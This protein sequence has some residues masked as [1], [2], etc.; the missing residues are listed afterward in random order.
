MKQRLLLFL[1][2]LSISHSALLVC[3]KEPSPGAPPSTQFSLVIP[4]G[5]A[6]D[7]DGRIAPNEWDD[8]ATSVIIVNPD[9]KSQVRMKHDG[10]FLYFVFEGVKHGSERLF[11]EI[12]IDPQNRRGDQWEQ[13]EWWFHV[14]FNLC[15]GK[16]EPNVY[17][18]DGVFQCSHQKEG[19][20]ANNPPATDVIEVKIS[21][22]KLG[23]KPAGGLRFGLA[24]GLTNATGD[25]T[26]KW[27]F[28]PQ[29]A[30]INRPASWATAI[31][32]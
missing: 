5:K 16:G 4:D 7:I 23:I 9:W 12:L 17:K 2:C 6:V 30:N 25:F 14:S 32:K 18:K 22:A 26:Q 19:W 8:V 13:G 28:S 3:D 21:F 15:E 31:L 10:E 11:P 29:T 20:A 27:F 1:F 24:L